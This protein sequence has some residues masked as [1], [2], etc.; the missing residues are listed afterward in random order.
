M[1]SGT[2]PIVT[3]FGVY[4][5]TIPDVLDGQVGFRCN[6]LQDFVDAAK[7]ANQF[8]EEDRQKVRNYGERFLMDNV[9]YEYQKWFQDLYQ[10]YLSTD[11]KTPG[12]SYLK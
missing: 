5:G 11:G 4:P 1:L 12:W 3:N 7:K 10:L 9:K 6:T 8:T 2:P